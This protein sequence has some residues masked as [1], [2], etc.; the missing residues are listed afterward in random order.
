MGEKDTT[1]FTTATTAAAA[2][3]TAD[4]HH[5]RLIL[6]LVVFNYCKLFGHFSPR[7]ELS[8]IS[9]EPKKNHVTT[10]VSLAFT[11]TTSGTV[12]YPHF[13]LTASAIRT[14]PSER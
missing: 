9:N 12:S 2:A 11:A 8:V 1:A 10:L 6:L 7:T 14:L 3:A 4:N 13:R 5:R